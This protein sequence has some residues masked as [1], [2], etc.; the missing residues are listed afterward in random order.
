[1]KAARHLLALLVAGITTA[2][3]G[4]V[5]FE[6]ESGVLGTNFLVGNN[7]GVIYISNT[8]NN[9]ASTPGIPGRVATYTVAFP[10]PGTYDLY[11]HMLAGP[12]GASDDSFLYGNGFGVK[13]PTN[14]GD[15]ILCNN[16][17]NAGYNIPTD[18]VAGAGTVSSGAWKWID[19]SQFNGGQAPI[20]FTVTA[21]NLTQT[22]Q[23]GGRE[24]GLNLDKFVFGT[25]G[26]SFTV[27][28]L[29]NGTESPAPE[30]PL[31]QLPPDIVAGNLIQFNDNGNWTWYCDE[32][33]IV[34]KAGGKIIVGSDGN[35][36]GMGGSARNGAIESAMF[37]LQNR[38]SKRYTMLASGTLGSRRSQYAGSDAAAGWQISGAMDRSQSKLSQLLQRL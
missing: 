21:G 12:A 22:F 30:P 11:A 38:T 35:G 14:T 26:T 27:S 29:D 36:S 28:N 19:V 8:N 18:V 3:A 13:S 25:A 31:L 17:A 1:M 5:T 33:S 6:A 15:W 10:A 7:S 16:L 9:T 2:R 4:I 37:D 23:I 32:R 20:S 24:D 34:D